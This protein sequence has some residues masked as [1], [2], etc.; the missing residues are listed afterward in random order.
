MLAQID[1]TKFNSLNN[2]F[3]LIL[4]FSGIL[5]SCNSS[6]LNEQNHK[7]EKNYWDIDSIQT[8]DFEI[9][10]RS[11]PYRLVLDVRNSIDYQYSNLYLKFSLVNDLNDTLKSAL[12]N[13]YLFNPKTGAPLGGGIGD[14][15]DIPLVIVDSVKFPLPGTYTL[16]AQHQMRD[17][18]LNHIMSLTFRLEQLK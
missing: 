7:F 3:C 8:F 5:Y 18:S 14:I 12:Q 9:Q 10:D 6:L 11:I 15:Y 13:F 16:N 1:K 2:K 4:F 17:D